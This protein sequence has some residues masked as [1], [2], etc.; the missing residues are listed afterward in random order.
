MSAARVVKALSEI[1][2]ALAEADAATDGR[3]YYSPTLSDVRTLLTALAAAEADL[4]VARLDGQQL[5]EL[6]EARVDHDEVWRNDA[7]GRTRTL[8]HSPDCAVCAALAG[9][10]SPTGVLLTPEDAERAESLF[11]SA[12]VH[13]TDGQHAKA[14]RLFDAALAVLRPGG[15]APNEEDV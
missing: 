7:N 1:R 10:G 15:A 12:F 9:C 2:A 13:E 14:H 6:I 8:V 3:V 11:R 4:A 5:R